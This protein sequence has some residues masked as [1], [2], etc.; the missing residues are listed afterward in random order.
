MNVL[1]LF[2]GL[3]GGAIALESLGIK[4]NKYYSSEIDKYANKL[5]NA[6]YPGTIQLGDITKWREWGVDFG[7]IDLLIAGFPCQAWSVAGKQGG[8]NDPR[9]ALVHDLIDVWNEIKKHKPDVKFMFENVKMKKDFLEYINDL[10]GVEPICINSALVSAQNRKRYYWTNIS[11]IEQP[12]DEGVLLFDIL[13][14]GVV[15]RDKSHLIDANYF[16]GGNLKSYFEKHRR[17][18]V[19]NKVKTNTIRAR[20]NN[21]SLNDKGYERFINKRVGTFVHEPVRVSE[22]GIRLTVCGT[23]RDDVKGF[24]VRGYEVATDGKSSFLTTVQKDNYVCEDFTIR[25][26]TVRECARLQTIPEHKI[27][28]M[29]NCGVS[30]TQIYKAIGNGW[31]HNVITHI[32]KGLL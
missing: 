15:D 14:N 16:K 1:S 20:C 22:R 8:D 27:D 24:L 31:T 7:K 17:Q 3:G 4:V 18:L 26:L 29:L 32:F 5:A 10:F 2:N 28:T 11:K 21:E 13:E 12:A 9:G 6:L 23:R 19:F 30:N 25:K